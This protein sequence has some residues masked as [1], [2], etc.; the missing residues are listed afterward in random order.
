[1]GTWGAGLYANDTGSDVRD[2]YI[3]YLRDGLSDEEAY[4]KLIDEFDEYLNDEDEEPLFW[5]A[6]A[7]VQWKSG[8]L[9]PEVKEKALTLIENNAGMELWAESANKG[10]GWKKTLQKLKSRLNSPMQKRKKFRKPEPFISNPW[11]IGD[12]YAYKF[13]TE[14]S[15]KWGVSGK[16][17]VLQK[18]GNIL[19]Y[20]DFFLSVIQVFDCVF[21]E[22]PS[23]KDI[24]NVRLLPLT[25]RP[26]E[27]YY[28]N[29][30]HFLCCDMLYF[31]KKDYEEDYFYHIGRTSIT[32]EE[33]FNKEHNCSELSWYDISDCLSQ[34][35]SVWHGVEYPI[36]Q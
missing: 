3:D 32:E 1:M 15:K 2:A 21:D 34:M 5:L 13:H 33:Q 30:E 25:P 23:I 36:G 20:D 29:F 24:Q 35:Y 12:V 27:H 9:R 10:A 14:D 18:V 16:Y 31:S 8:R 4:K 17:I 26:Y 7:D 6:L 11:E 28:P 22:L 19:Y